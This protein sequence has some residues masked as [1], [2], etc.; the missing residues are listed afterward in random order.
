MTRRETQ[1]SLIFTIIQLQ[2]NR[3]KRIVS[4]FLGMTLSLPI[5]YPGHHFGS[6]PRTFINV[7]HLSSAHTN[8]VCRWFLPS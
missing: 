3:P 1:Y 5:C 6:V 2:K 4:I 7:L 8:C